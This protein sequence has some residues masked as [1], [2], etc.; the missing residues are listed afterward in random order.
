MH[1]F[2]HL[3][4]DD[5]PCELVDFKNC[6][7]HYQYASSS[8][9]ES[10]E[11]D[12]ELECTCPGPSSEVLYQKEEKKQVVDPNEDPDQLT[13]KLLSGSPVR[14]G[15]VSIFSR[16]L[17]LC[18]WNWCTFQ[19]NLDAS[20]NISDFLLQVIL[21]LNR[22]EESE[23]VADDLENLPEEEGSTYSVEIS[24]AP[25]KRRPDSEEEQEFHSFNFQRPSVQEVADADPTIQKHEFHGKLAPSLWK[26]RRAFLS[27]EIMKDLM[28][29]SQGNLGARKQLDILHKMK[30]LVSPLSSVFL[31][32]P[33]LS[34]FA[35]WM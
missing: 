28:S 1:L 8:S 16:T 25:S 31:F 20:N 22:I 26:Y 23:T 2:H 15:K 6:P 34:Y 17:S 14:L 30:K 11:D 7:V 24:T 32:F 9:G 19:L 4:Q 10:D 33:L 35:R 13:T 5:E 27:D 29:D 3:L 18:L 21:R 12:D